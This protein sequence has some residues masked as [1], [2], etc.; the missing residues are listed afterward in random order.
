MDQDTALAPLLASF[1]DCPIRIVPRSTEAYAEI[2]RMLWHPVSLNDPGAAA[3]RAA[4]L[5]AT[6]AE[7]VQGAPDDPAV[8]AAEVTDLTE[9]DIPFFA[10]TPGHGRLAGPGGTAWLP[11]QDLIADA[12]DR[13]RTADF[14]VDH[15]VIRAAL[16][17]AYL[18][19]GWMPG[20]RRM[21]PGQVRREDL[22]RRRRDT[23]A[24]LLD[25][26][27]DSAIRAE[28]GTVTWIARCCTRPG[29]RCSRWA[30]TATAAYQG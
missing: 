16:V 30:W 8:I 12:L 19:D 2:G 20:E 4:G 24:S 21:R 11:E 26:L 7:H 17:S 13:W 25:K 10:T 5:L 9:G 18:N 28:D 29:G 14:G 23:A 27:R 22:E 15:Q 6:M 1:R 3:D